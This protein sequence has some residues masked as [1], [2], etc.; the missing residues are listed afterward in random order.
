MWISEDYLVWMDVC[1]QTLSITARPELLA[2][3]NQDQAYAQRL[4]D[5]LPLFAE[6]LALF[7]KLKPSEPLIA[8]SHWSHAIWTLHR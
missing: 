1:W 5:P 6:E 7:R 2:L 4:T 3:V 8:S